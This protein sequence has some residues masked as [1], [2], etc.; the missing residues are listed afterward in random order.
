MYS[1]YLDE[2]SPKVEE[3][4]PVSPPTSAGESAVAFV[5]H[6]NRCVHFNSLDYGEPTFA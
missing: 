2:P 1:S 5:W 6:A 4:G 3:A